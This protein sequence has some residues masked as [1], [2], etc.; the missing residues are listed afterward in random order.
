MN[1]NNQEHCQGQYMTTMSIGRCHFFHK[2]YT[3]LTARS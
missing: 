1:S 3:S 2:V